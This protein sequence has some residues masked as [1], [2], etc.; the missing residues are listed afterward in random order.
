MDRGTFLG[1]L[2]GG[3]V[4]IISI[5]LND[6][7]KVVM[8]WD[9]PSV[10]IVLGGAV[11]AVMIAYP[12]EDVL[13]T[14]K[15]MRIVFF[16]QKTNPLDT[17][18]LLVSL[19]E[20]ARKEGLLS[21]EN[22]MDEVKDGFLSSGLRMA[23]DG[24]TPEVLER[25]MTTEI[26][27]VYA[28]HL[29]YKSILENIGKYAPAFGMLGTVIGLVLMLADFD[30]ATVGKGMAV[31]LLTTLYGALLANLVVCPMADKLGFLNEFES[32]N[33]EIM[34]KGILSIQAGENPRVIKQNLL[35]YIPANRRPIEK[36]GE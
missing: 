32:T 16:N 3:G 34:L 13:G 1:I 10:M 8:F 11:G 18:N 19:A 36:E 4:L 33:R 6:V 17:I 9:A 15:Y 21:L 7:R 27:S 29:Y 24:Y 26:E 30:P 35:N 2:I 22:R 12:L 28:R 31:A 23:M 5:A 20:V 25:A 14:F